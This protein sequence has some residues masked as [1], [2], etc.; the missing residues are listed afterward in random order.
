MRNILIL[1]ILLLNSAL[2]PQPLTLYQA[3]Q[4]ALAHN[5]TVMYRARQNYQAAHAQLE[6][7]ESA[8]RTQVNLSLNSYRS[9]S[10]VFSGNQYFSTHS[11]ATTPNLALDYTLLTPFGSRTSIGVGYQTQMDGMSHSFYSS[12]QLSL[13]YQQ[14]LSRAGIQSGHA[15]MFR[16]RSNF[17]N[18]EQSFQLQ[19]EGLIL[20][21]INSYFQLWQSYRS[22][23]QSKLD[24]ESTRRVLEIAELRL[25]AG[26]LSEFE[27][28]N[29][30]VQYR[31]AEDNVKVALNSL[32]T[33]KRSFLRLLG[34][35]LDTNVQLIEEI[36]MDTI[37]F[38]MEY[39]IQTANRN[40]LE[41]KQ[42]EISL[43]LTELSLQQTAAGNKPTL[44]LNGN[45]SLSSEYDV[46]LGTAFSEFPGR[47]WSVNASL[48]FPILDGGAQKNQIRIAK[49]SYDMQQKSLELLREDIAIEI[50]EYF[51]S[52]QLNQNR[53][54]SLTMNLKIAE[55]A[56]KIAEL[57]FSQGQISSTEIE[58]IRQRYTNAQQS[59]NSAKISYITQSAQLAKAMGMLAEWVEKQY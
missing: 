2:Y 57:R 1:V 37:D 19:K 53:I 9:Y 15:D 14:P 5:E 26:Q 3:I 44:Y 39:A 46:P 22:L 36:K 12:P 50:E 49:S 45:Y 30:R 41:I 48:S 24:V 32:Q 47:N 17:V 51:R 8:Y 59:L 55:E 13:T 11:Q 40:R 56:L 58:N 35:D 31:V 16:A 7:S 20:S 10:R 43:Q 52:L 27:V 28:M 6:L 25:K 18:A 29:T 23:E 21:V 4:Q 42:N 54:E 34:L 38:D 33:Q